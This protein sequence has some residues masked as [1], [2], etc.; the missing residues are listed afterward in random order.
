MKKSFT[1]SLALLGQMIFAQ[2]ATPN[3]GKTYRIADLD[4][5]TDVIT[6]DQ[7]TNRYELTD[8]LTISVNDTFL[9]DTDYTLVIADGKLITIAGTIDVNA[10]KEVLFTSDN[11][12]TTYFKGIRIEEGATAS[13]NHF[14]MVYGGGIRSLNESFIMN[15][16]E[17]SY[18]YGGIS[19]G[20]AIN[21]SRGNPI[22]K[23]STFKFNKTPVVG[24][25]ANQS[26]AL[27][28]ENNHL[29]GNNQDNSNRPQINMGPSGNNPTIIRGNTIIGDREKTRVGGISV[30]SLLGVTNEA[31]I[32]NNTIRDNRYGITISGGNSKGKII[33]NILEDNNT[34]TNPTNGGSGISIYLASNPTTNVIDIFD[35]Q[36]RGSLWGI[37]NIEKGAFINLGTAE[38]P[39]NNIFS[40]NGNGGIN[41]ALYNNSVNDVSAVGNCWIENQK[42]SE[43][44][45][46]NVIV[47]QKDDPTLGLVDYSDFLC[48]NLATSEVNSKKFSLYPNPT[49]GNFTVDTKEKSPYQIFD[50]NGKLIHQGE[51]KIGQNS[52][53]TNLPKGVYIFKTNQTSSKIIVK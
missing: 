41:Y 38:R 44:Q 1:L 27:T 42:S 17:I 50:V 12:G 45:V 48:S 26:V 29:E 31:I 49:N 33:G 24:S 2:Y 51:L 23:N 25:G 6:F 4:A 14:K 7:T 43:Q 46:E 36:I 28:F 40:N 30:S 34:E 11:P 47:H 32:E 9:S 15:N 16:S 5:L 8:D 10:P 39:G 21:F 37:T 35:N 52:I 19:T 13:F 22:I 53:Q 18:Q 20:G 3:D